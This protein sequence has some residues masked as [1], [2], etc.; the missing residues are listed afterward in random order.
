MV[1]LSLPSDRAMVGFLKKLALA[2]RPIGDD[3]WS[4]DHIWLPAMG[5]SC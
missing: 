5:P 2:L 3:C 1:S 4:D